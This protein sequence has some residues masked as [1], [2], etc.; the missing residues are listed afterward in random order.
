MHKTT[1]DKSPCQ[2]GIYQMLFSSVKLVDFI[3][4]LRFL[5]ICIEPSRQAREVLPGK[6]FYLISL[7]PL[8]AGLPAE[9]MAGSG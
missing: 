2:K 7:I 3:G 1:E 6:H 8:P 4:D 9:G 5:K